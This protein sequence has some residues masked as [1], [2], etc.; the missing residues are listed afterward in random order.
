MAS[1]YKFWYF[2]TNPDSKVWKFHSVSFS[3]IA[4]VI[5]CKFG[6]NPFFGNQQVY[7]YSPNGYEHEVLFGMVFPPTLYFVFGARIGKS[8]MFICYG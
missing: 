6:A 2:S 3:G 7:S 1:L 8:G 4:V 5:F